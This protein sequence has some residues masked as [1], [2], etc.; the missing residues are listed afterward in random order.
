MKLWQKVSSKNLEKQGASNHEATLRIEN[1]TVGKDREMDM[2]LAEF[3]VIGSMAHA[4]MLESIGLLETNELAGIIKECLKIYNDI[5][6][7][8]F[9]IEKNIEDVHS[10]V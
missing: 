2:Y 10:Q 1:F 4:I 3:D 7:G 6:N 8:K 5:I 9:L